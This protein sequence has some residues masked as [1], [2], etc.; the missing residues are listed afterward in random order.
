MEQ[1]ISNQDWNPMKNFG[2]CHFSPKHSGLRIS[3]VV[4]SIVATTCH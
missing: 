3:V 1:N 4:G 2:V